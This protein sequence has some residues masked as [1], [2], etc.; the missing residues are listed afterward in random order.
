MAE[1]RRAGAVQLVTDLLPSA[2]SSGARRG[3]NGLAALIALLA[4]STFGWLYTQNVGITLAVMPVAALA[5]VALIGL[6][7]LRFEYF[8][9]AC[10]FIRSSLDISKANASL[11][12]SSN[13]PPAALA[14]LFVIASIFWLWRLRSR[15]GLKP[16][17]LLL[18]ASFFVLFAGGVSLAAS[19]NLVVSTSLLG[20]MGAAVVMLWV[21]ENMITDK[22]SAIRV[23]VAAAA[24][25]IIPVALALF[26]MVTGTGGIRENGF[27]RVMG[28]FVHPNPFALYLTMMIVVAVAMFPA[29]QPGLHRRLL[30]VFIA[31]SSVAMIGTYTRGAWI[32]VG[33]GLVVVGLL[34]SR[35]LL[36]GMI[37]GAVLVVGIAPSTAQRFNEL[38]SKQTF[39]SR[40]GGNSFEWRQRAW[41][42]AVRLGKTSPV[43]G[44][45]LDMVRVRSTAGNLPPHNDWVRAFSEMGIIGVI[46]FSSFV[47]A[48]GETARRAIK[49]GRGPLRNFAVGFAG[50]GVGLLTLTFSENVV[51]QVVFL[52]YFFAFAAVAVAIERGV[53]RAEPSERW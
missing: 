19:N 29:L 24:S 44:I 20:K 8:V 16:M 53:L 4:A 1:G 46:A 7:V 25:A 43:I 5:G 22:Q 34:Q 14:A 10:I 32:A 30:L 13:G 39:E 52:W 12:Q 26:Q 33:A 18:K 40:G 37:V 50:A 28:T 36:I 48:I 21:L 11:D 2:P 35:A 49:R 42:E 38:S 23:L 6:A 9:L 27:H 17:S 31:A 3:A 47:L 15:G 51:S 41:R 45:G